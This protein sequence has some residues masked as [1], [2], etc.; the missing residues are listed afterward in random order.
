MTAPAVA[1]SE[2]V[3]VDENSGA[4]AAIRIAFTE[5]VYATSGGV[6][7]A[8]HFE[9]VGVPSDAAP[10]E[11]GEELLLELIEVVHAGR[12]LSEEGVEEVV[13]SVALAPGSSLQGIELVVSVSSRVGALQDAAGNVVAEEWSFVTNEV[14]AV[15]DA[16][17]GSGVVTTTEAVRVLPVQIEPPWSPPPAA[18]SEDS[19]FEVVVA[20]A[21]VAAIACCCALLMAR[22]QR[23]LRRL[24]ALLIRRDT[25]LLVQRMLV[26][27]EDP[28]DRLLMGSKSKEELMKMAS[29][30]NSG[31]NEQQPSEP[32]TRE[33]HLTLRPLEALVQHLGAFGSN[34]SWPTSRDSDFSRRLSSQSSSSTIRRMASSRCSQ[35]ASERQTTPRLSMRSRLASANKKASHD[36]APG[37][38]RL[39]TLQSGESLTGLAAQ[40]SFDALNH[41]EQASSSEKADPWLA[42]P[43]P[44]QGDMSPKAPMGSVCEEPSDDNEYAKAGV[45]GAEAE[46][47]GASSSA[48]CVVSAAQGASVSFSEHP[49][50][51]IRIPAAAPGA[52]EVS[53]PSSRRKSRI[54]SLRLSLYARR[55]SRRSTLRAS[56]DTERL[57]T[58]RRS[59]ER[60]LSSRLIEAAT[61]FAMKPTDTL[62]RITLAKE[63]VTILRPSTAEQARGEFLSSKSKAQLTEHTDQSERALTGRLK[64]VKGIKGKIRVARCSLNRHRRS[65]MR[66]HDEAVAAAVPRRERGAGKFDKALQHGDGLAVVDQALDAEHVQHG[67]DASERATMSKRLSKAEAELLD[68]LHGIEEDI[69]RVQAELAWLSRPCQMCSWLSQLCA[70]CVRCGRGGVKARRRIQPWYGSESQHINSPG[71]SGCNAAVAADGAS[72][73][74]PRKLTNGFGSADGFAVAK[75]PRE[76]ART[77]PMS[78]DEKL[79]RGE[80]PLATVDLSPGKLPSIDARL[81]SGAQPPQMV[82]LS[83]G[84]LPPLT[85]VPNPAGEG[86]LTPVP[87]PAGKD[88]PDLLDERRWTPASSTPTS[89]AGP[90]KSFTPFMPLDPFLE[91]DGQSLPVGDTPPLR[92]PPRRSR[93][94]PPPGRPPGRT[95]PLPPL[96]PAPTPPSP[97]LPPAPW[98]ESPSTPRRELGSPS[99]GQLTSSSARWSS[100]RLRTPPAGQCCSASLARVSPE[101]EAIG[102]IAASL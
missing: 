27:A 32:Q 74:K 16:S 68:D 57:S 65:R 71:A 39:R 97:P 101:P 81:S 20:T 9:A 35:L 17:S 69:A 8:D 92:E 37:Q 59:M 41:P 1:T 19:E 22:R 44:A 14:D 72:A 63:M 95:P 15:G 13:L 58:Q 56:T 79:G 67:V 7:S 10:G 33:R 55:A 99:T 36:V 3:D 88:G 66:A 48:A 26:E 6:V 18:P 89:A 86:P 73:A 11:A 50:Q 76:K 12:Q 54:S 28:G 94:R 77:V 53:I 29:D 49:T 91:E 23:L 25:V 64:R 2:W 31:Q 93:R 62:D 51:E 70:R 34:G 21:P 40:S 47:K 80:Q 78:I 46:V 42:H 90:R 75:G 100:G 87:K 85:P 84:K 83:P 102:P 38:P 5:G 4:T 43:W 60:R 98:R 61:P 52:A 45:A 96:P 24:S 82:D 30:R